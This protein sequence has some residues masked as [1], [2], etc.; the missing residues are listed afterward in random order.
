M[1]GRCM[2]NSGH[3]GSPG[4]RVM[5]IFVFYVSAQ[6]HNIEDFEVYGGLQAP[7][8][9]SYLFSLNFP[10][11]AV[12][13]MSGVPFLIRVMTIF[14]KTWFFRGCVEILLSP[15]RSQGVPHGQNLACT[16]LPY[17]KRF[18]HT[19]RTPILIKLKVLSTFGG[20]I[21]VENPINRGPIVL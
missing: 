5:T 17:P 15:I 6:I 1:V 11:N 9:I 2:P 19:Q 13:I 12:R 16:F 8:C 14:V 18:F 10:S 21:K 7:G 20:L 4:T 3:G